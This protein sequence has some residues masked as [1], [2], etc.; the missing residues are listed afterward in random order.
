MIQLSKRGSKRTI[1]ALKK[2]KYLKGEVH[3]TLYNL[4]IPHR[5]LST[6]TCTIHTV[7]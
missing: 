1:L 5:M 7:I 3:Q 6:L 4:D 2:S